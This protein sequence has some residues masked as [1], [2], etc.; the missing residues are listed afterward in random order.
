VYD[1]N[2]GPFRASQLGGQILIP[3]SGGK[4]LYSGDER[5]TPEGATRKNILRGLNGRNNSDQR[6][7]GKG[8]GGRQP[9]ENS[10]L[11][12]STTE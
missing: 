1:Q 4:D 9:T 7:T 10:Y 12:R 2:L 11:G 3:I 8:A 5:E 6:S